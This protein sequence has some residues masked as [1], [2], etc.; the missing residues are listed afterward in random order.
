MLFDKGLTELLLVPEGKEGAATIPDQT[1]TVLAST[2][3]HGV[4]LTAVMVGNGSAAFTSVDGVLYS[5]DKAKA[6]YCP[7]GAGDAV[8]LPAETAEIGPGAFADA[9]LASIVASGFVQTIDPSAFSDD[10]KANAV[11]ALAGG[12]NYDARKAVWEGAGFSRFAEPAQPGDTEGPDDETSGFAYTLLDDYTLA[13]S[14]KGR[15]GPE[16]ELV[17]PSSA[18]LGGTIYRVSAIEDGGFSGLGQVSSAVIPSGVTAIGDAAFSGC[19]S[20][21]SVSLAEGLRSIGAQSFAGT[22]LEQVK[23]PA[24]VANV[25]SGAFADCGALSRI[26]AHTNNVDVAG[27]AFAGCTNVGIYCPFEESGEYPWNPGLVASGNHVLPYGLALSGEPLVLEVGEEADLF[28]GGVREVPEGMEIAYSYSATVMSVDAGVVTAKKAGTADV[29]VV[30][31]MGGEVLA[32][33][34]RTVEVT[35]AAG[36]GSGDQPESLAPPI[37]NVLTDPN[38]PIVPL[39]DVAGSAIEPYGATIT[40]DGLIFEQVVAGEWTIVGHSPAMV[41]SSHV[42]LPS[43]ID[44]LPVTSIGER[45]FEGFMCVSIVIPATIKT[46]GSYAFANSTFSTVS[47]IGA[48]TISQFAFSRCTSLSSVSLPNTVTSIGLGAFTGCALV[49]VTIPNS[50]ADLDG[51]VFRECRQL[52]EAYLGTGIKTLRTETFTDCTALR[53]VTVKSLITSVDQYAFDVNKSNINLKLPK[54]ADRAIWQNV[55]F[56]LF[57]AYTCSVVFNSQ[58]GN[59]ITTQLISGGAYVTRPSEE[60]KRAGYAFKGWFSSSECLPSQLWNFAGTK[61]YDS[62]TLYAGWDPAPSYEV[63]YDSNGAYG[64]PIR[65]TIVYGDPPKPVID[66][67]FGRSGYVFNCWNTKADGTGTDYYPRTSTLSNLSGPLTLYAQ[68][69]AEWCRITYDLDGG[70]DPGNPDSYTIESVAITLKA[71]TKA[72]CTFLGWTGSNGTTPQASVTIAAGSTGD[73]SYK[74]N[75]AAN[76]TIA[77]NANGGTGSMASMSMVEGT[78]KNLAANGFSRTGYAFTGWATTAGGSVAY[79]DKQSVSN[80]TTA[81]GGTVT[82]YAKW[83]PVTY[84]IE[85]SLGGGSASGN[86][87]TYTIESAA[88]ALKAPTRANHVFAG[89]TGS[90]GST[91]QTSVT[92]PAGST[93]DKSYTANWKSTYTIQFD[94][95]GGTGKTDSISMVYGTAKTLTPNGFTRTGH[96]FTGWKDDAGRTYSDKQSVNELTAVAGATVVLRAQ[97]SVNSYALE[98]VSDGATQKT[99]SVPYGSLL[100]GSYAPPSVSKKGHAFQSWNKP[101]GTAWDFSS[102]TMPANALTLAASWKANTYEVAFHAN[103]GSGAGMADQSMT[104]G[105]AANLAQCGFTRTG[106]SFKGWST[107]PNA[108]AATYANGAQV[109]NLSEVQGARVNLYA[110]W[111]AN[112]YT[113]VFHANHQ[114]DSSTATQKFKYDETAKT[115][116]PNAFSRTGWTFDKWNTAADGSGT[117]YADKALVSSP[118][119]ASGQF[120][121][122]AQWTLNTYSVTFDSNGGSDVASQ[123]V[124][125]G[126]RAADPGAPSR[127]GYAF[128]GWYRNAE[129]TGAAWNFAFDTVPVGGVA[130]YAKWTANRFTVTLDPGAGAGVLATRSYTYAAPNQNLPALSELGFSKT[131]YAFAGWTVAADGSGAVYADG[132]DVATGL[133][134]GAP[135]TLHAQWKANS[136]TVKFDAGEGSLGSVPAQLAA[137]FDEDVALPSAEPS[138]RGYAFLGWS[139]AAGA[140]EAQYSAGRVLAKP[141]F[142]SDPGGTATLHAV[143][144]ANSYAV[145]FDPNATAE[146]GLTGGP[147]PD[148][149]FVYDA[150]PAPLAANAY[151]RT[152][153]RFAGW[154]EN[155]D[156]SG[157]LH[158]DKDQVRNLAESGT[159]TLYAKWEAN[160]YFAIFFSNAPEGATVTTSGSVMQQLTYDAKAALQPTPFSC[161]GYEFAG[162]NTEA[163]GSGTSYADGAEVLNLTA[164]HSGM[165][166]LYAQWKGSAYTVRFDRNAADATGS[167]DDLELNWGVRADLPESPFKRDGWSF[168]G[169]STEPDG[170]G[171]TYAD[172]ESVRDLPQAGKNEVTLYARWTP[173]ISVAAPIEPKIEITADAYTGSWVSAQP[174]ESQFVSRTPVALRVAS[175]KCEPLGDSTASV[176]PDQAA[177]PGVSIGMDAGGGNR[178]QVAIGNDLI[179]GSSPSFV[180]EAGSVDAPS[181]LPVKLSLTA[182]SATKVVMKDGPAAVA[183]LTYTFEPV[184]GVS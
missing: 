44:E 86:P 19:A 58:G 175:M 131:G 104:Y 70:S 161:S 66:C 127:P 55:G 39:G 147:M 12:D 136:Y 48:T 114:G 36:E 105:T 46:I 130:L 108:T 98:Y 26:V 159:V 99:A 183:K 83:T 64:S 128:G 29:A 143:W 146:Q 166:S 56:S 118:L 144:K 37:S 182:D 61:V 45:A 119:A 90:N 148:Q 17:I 18:E 140:S 3:S 40:R 153:Y 10:V 112:E 32:R 170:T 52:K 25:G 68:W 78:A 38:D 51:Y 8:A 122:Y 7:A 89:W 160:S 138:R 100:S 101:D 31:E 74:A 132:A 111:E 176:F 54:D 168:A 79:S 95:N 178:T 84:K 157:A 50:V 81:P 34:I 5:F 167:M 172:G 27:D 121:L 115:L 88:M 179:F 2:L 162:W 6:L 67:P 11:V 106:Y 72:N 126:E 82:L 164:A 173:V 180:I 156:G 134:T 24:S 97:W 77:F 184:G 91:P 94:A 93:G 9:P 21:A 20:L 137:T 135:V 125:Y 76:Y 96:T 123:T 15:G 165:V 23:V 75:W 169:W 28:E 150:D 53:E 59:S 154:T 152:G 57:G 71:P 85:Y 158:P 133:S 181:T 92:I 107:D 103:G 117:S 33:A 163:D 65:E 30:L 13:V 49:S 113:V 41:G 42:V 22:A 60:V 142:S 73:R 1:V 124:G 35:Q 155:A 87:D 116:S 139:E 129:L 63:T 102:G 145:R 47:I 109:S 141:N 43:A 69:S 62:I 110:V 120:H 177:W 80:L 14:W 174:T 16:G 171:S 151:S 149:E 4:K